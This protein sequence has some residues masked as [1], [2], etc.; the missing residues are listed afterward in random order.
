MKAFKI[1]VPTVAIAF[2]MS[3]QQQNRTSSQSQG[4]GS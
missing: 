4:N 2:T 3:C 1:L